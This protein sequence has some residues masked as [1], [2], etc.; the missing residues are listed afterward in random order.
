MVSDSLMD[1][2][3]EMR[4]LGSVFQREAEFACRVN[5]GIGSDVHAI[6]EIDEDD[7]VPG[8]RLVGSAIGD[9]AGEGL[10]GGQRWNDWNQDQRES[11][12][13][14]GLNKFGQNNSL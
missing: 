7:L 1:G 10:G 4:T 11:G 3:N 5:F 2:A 9:S 12:K 8:G 6:G 13:D 14:E